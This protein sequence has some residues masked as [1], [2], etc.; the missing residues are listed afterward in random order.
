MNLHFLSVVFYHV[1]I[2][3]ILIHFFINETVIFTRGI[4]GES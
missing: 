2:L 3:N 4:K 1:P